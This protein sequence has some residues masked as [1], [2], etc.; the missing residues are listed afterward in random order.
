M[1]DPTTG[2]LA[3]LDVH[4]RDTRGTAACVLFRDWGDAAPEARL[5]R[6]IEDVAPYAPGQFYRRELPCLLAVLEQVPSLPR[7]VVV[8]GYV[9]LSPARAPGLGAHLHAA[10]GAAI[11]VVGVAKTAFP[12]APALPV[13][14]GRSRAPLFVSAIGIPTREA[15]A[16]VA[17]MHGPHRIPTLLGLV[18]RLGRRA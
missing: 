10:L 6:V 2:P 12:G 1:T 16:H 9:W 18:D 5:T 11:P 13:L 4:Y 14:R 15:A 8:D 7:L 17:S 3:C